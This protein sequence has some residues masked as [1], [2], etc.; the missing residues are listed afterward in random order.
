MSGLSYAGVVTLVYVCIVY[1]GQ[2]LCREYRI[3]FDKYA[4]TAYDKAYCNVN[5]LFQI[6]KKISGSK[7]GSTRAN[8]ALC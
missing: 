6:T 3:Q 2:I 5:G 8:D 1:T 7:N 4:D